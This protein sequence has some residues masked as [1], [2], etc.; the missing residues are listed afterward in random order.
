MLKPDFF[1]VGAPK[2]G[3]TAMYTYLQAH[4]DIFM[5]EVKEPYYFCSDLGFHRFRNEQEYLKLFSVASPQQRIGE[6]STWYLYSSQAAAA[7]HAFNTDARIIVMLRNPVD[8]MYS[9]YS[10]F[11]YIGSEETDSFEAAL[12]AEEERKHG[13]CIP[14]GVEQ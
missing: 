12:A 2:C 6:A 13:N 10:H 14:E 11:L 3:T 7:I 1:I 8:M 4:P 5:S 9:L